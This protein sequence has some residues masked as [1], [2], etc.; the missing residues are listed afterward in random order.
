MQIKISRGNESEQLE[1]TRVT[2]YLGDEVFRIYP[3]SNSRSKI[4]VA[5]KYGNQLKIMPVEN[6]TLVIGTEKKTEKDGL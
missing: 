3:T 4:T 5:C 6:S 1:V 2:I